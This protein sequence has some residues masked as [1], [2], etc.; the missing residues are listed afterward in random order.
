VVLVIYVYP[1]GMSEFSS[2]GSGFA[3]YIKQC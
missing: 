1:F 2:S 3:N